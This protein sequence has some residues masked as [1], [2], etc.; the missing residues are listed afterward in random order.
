MVCP[1]DH[2]TLKPFEMTTCETP[3][4]YLKQEYPLP[5]GITFMGHTNLYAS[6]AQ[7]SACV[8]G[9]FASIVSPF[10]GFLASGMKR[11]YQL[12]DFSDLLPGHGGMTDRLDCVSVLTLF[13]YQVLS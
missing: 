5:L 13:A 3:T 11:A 8:F 7:L 10:G 4:L 9:L 6:P 1:V 2:L 12:K